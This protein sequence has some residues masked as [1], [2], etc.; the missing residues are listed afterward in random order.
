MYK[1]KSA[2]RISG[3]P[4]I[5]RHSISGTVLVLCIMKFNLTQ[6]FTVAVGLIGCVAAT[7]TSP[8]EVEIARM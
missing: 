2:R 8:G 4:N 3:K 7:P 5:N 1:D 6:I